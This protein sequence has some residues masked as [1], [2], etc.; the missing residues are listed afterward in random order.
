MLGAREKGS[1]YREP[2]PWPNPH[3]AQ[4]LPFTS[5]KRNIQE[6]REYCKTEGETSLY[7]EMVTYRI[8]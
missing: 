8:A 4:Y 2:V 3:L 5:I 1:N 7:Q 6:K